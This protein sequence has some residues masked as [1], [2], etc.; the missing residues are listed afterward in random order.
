MVETEKF[1]IFDVGVCNYL[2]RRAP[3]YGTP[4]FG[5]SFEHFIL[6]EILAYRAYRSPDLEVRFWRTSNQQEVDFIIND[7]EMALEIKA[8][9]RT[10]IAD[11][12]HLATLR[13]DGPIKHR[14]LI[15]FDE[16]PKTYTDTFGD[17]QVLPWQDFLTRLWRD[18][19][20]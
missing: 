14:I 12:R 8:S 9:S 4:E 20:F 11:C 18:E 10:D 2:A 7:R 16:V 15:S 19:F 5:K 1:F 13:Q 17:I 3:A 6:M